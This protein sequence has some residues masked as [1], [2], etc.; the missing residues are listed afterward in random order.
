[1]SVKSFTINTQPHEAKIGTHVLYFVPET[2]GTVFIE[3]YTELVQVQKTIADKKE[4]E[5]SP[6]D[7]A[8]ISQATR[9]FITR[10]LMPESVET[11]AALALPDRV[12][13]QLITWTAELY[14]GGQGKDDPSGQ[15]SGS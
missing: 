11:F 8:A 12:L 5:T 14:G 1:M 7:F 9:A 6:E 2:V 15:S 3:A 4:D 10:L 13:L